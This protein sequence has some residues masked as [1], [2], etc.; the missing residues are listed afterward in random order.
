MSK[1]RD[2]EKS[3]NTSPVVSH[4]LLDDLRQMIEEMRNGI[5]ATVNAGL[6]MLYWRIGRRVNDEI[7]KYERA[8]YGK[9]I[10]ISLARQ[11][12]MEYGRGFSDK[13][14]GTCFGSLKFL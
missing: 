5:A 4:L 8:E 3:D 2:L 13:S 11:L 14:L 12:E 1:K 6:T 7:L 9:E 10:V